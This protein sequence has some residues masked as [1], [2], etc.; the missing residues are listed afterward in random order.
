V[1]AEASEGL[2]HTVGHTTLPLPTLQ[3]TGSV[4]CNPVQNPAGNSMTKRPTKSRRV[5]GGSTQ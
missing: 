5:G 2:G 3:G 4:L 1:S